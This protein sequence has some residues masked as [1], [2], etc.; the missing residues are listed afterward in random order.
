MYKHEGI[1]RPPGN[2]FRIYRHGPETLYND[3]LHKNSLRELKILTLNDSLG[4]GTCD[5]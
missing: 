5:A 4:M 3:R 2:L 1:A